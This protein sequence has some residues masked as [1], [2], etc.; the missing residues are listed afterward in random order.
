M[1]CNILKTSSSVSQESGTHRLLKIVAVAP[2]AG[3][4]RPVNI[5]SHLSS[6]TV[7][8]HVPWLSAILTAVTK[9]SKILIIFGHG[10]YAAEVLKGQAGRL[11]HPCHLAALLVEATALIAARR[12]LHCRYLKEDQKSS[13]ALHCWSWSWWHCC[14]RDR[15]LHRDR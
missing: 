9:T 7:R 4:R 11:R 5:I 14:T 6:A 2:R 8:H 10:P 13:K 3:W 15:W 12:A 1:F